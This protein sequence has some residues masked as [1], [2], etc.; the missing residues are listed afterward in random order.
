M[1][2]VQGG[3]QR[4]KAAFGGGREDC[5]KKQNVG[6]IARAQI[7]VRRGNSTLARPSNSLSGIVAEVP[8][9]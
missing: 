5:K 8:L 6:A 3:L 4:L 9:C 7:R 1:L 2:R